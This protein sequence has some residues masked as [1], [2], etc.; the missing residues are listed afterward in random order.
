MPDN[1]LAVATFNFEHGEWSPEHDDYRHLHLL[2]EVIAQVPDLDILFLGFSERH[3]S[4][5]ALDLLFH[6]ADM[7]ATRTG[8]ALVPGEQS[9][10]TGRLTR[11]YD[12]PPAGSCSSCLPCTGEGRSAC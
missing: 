7:S 11:Q 8:R 1:L 5:N 9:A 12:R 2:P 10:S 6:V 3:V 4:C